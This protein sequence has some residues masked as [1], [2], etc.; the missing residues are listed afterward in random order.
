MIE[1]ASKV[2]HEIPSL[3]V[4][5]FWLCLPVDSVGF[6]SS[7]MKA[8]VCVTGGSGRGD[9]HMG[10]FLSC[11]PCTRRKTASVLWLVEL[12]PILL[13]KSRSR[14]ANSYRLGKEK[15]QEEEGIV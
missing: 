11:L 9:A 14:D 12:L 10:F 4:S 5:Y 15:K 1:C 2:A 3:K 7:D 6:T 13:R 8:A